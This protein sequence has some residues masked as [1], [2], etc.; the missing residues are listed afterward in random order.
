VFFAAF[1]GMIILRWRVPECGAGGKLVA[2]ATFTITQFEEVEDG[3]L[4]AFAARGAMRG[5]ALRAVAALDPWQ[6]HWVPAERAWWISQDA[7]TRL[8]RR[9]PLVG[10]ALDEW[11][12]RP[13]DLAAYIASGVWNARP[14][15]IIVVPPE[16]AAAY[17]KLGL[18]P[19]ASES[20]VVAARRTLARAHHPDTGGDHRVMVAINTATDTVMTW[21][22][23]RRT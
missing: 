21:L 14:R 18:A 23:H 13:D 5:E 15:R 1:P 6:R 19:G 8:A 4:L 16:V 10:T 9:L 11:R 2:A 17:R 7:I 3:Y 22:D 12:Q 20:D